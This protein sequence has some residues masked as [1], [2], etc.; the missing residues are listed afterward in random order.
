MD[1]TRAQL[2]AELK[3]KHPG[4][5]HELTAELEEGGERLV[6][7]VREPKRTEFARFARDANQD[8]HRAMSNLFF[9]CLLDPAPEHVQEV[10][11]RYPGLVIPLA[12]KLLAIAKA[13]LEVLEKKL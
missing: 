12:S 9:D 13:N 11:G 1:E 5:L 7:I 3:A 4:P 6:V 2:I 10:C 8:A